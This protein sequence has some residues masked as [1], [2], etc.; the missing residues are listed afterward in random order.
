MESIYTND[1]ARNRKLRDEAMQAARRA[2]V[3]KQREFLIFAARRH[4]HLAIQYRRFARGE[5]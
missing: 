5:L 4:G 3:P 2:L 1:A